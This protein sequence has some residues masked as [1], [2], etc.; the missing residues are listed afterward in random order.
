MSII[1]HGEH[2]P[3]ESWD[4]IGVMDSQDAAD[5]GVESSTVAE[6]DGDAGGLSPDERRALVVLLKNPF[7]TSESNPREWKTTLASRAAIGQRLNDLYLELAVDLDREVAYKRPVTSG[8]GARAFPTLLY[9]AAWK[10]EETALLVF[11]R[12]RERSER[13]R[14]EVQVRVSRGEMLDYLREN[15]P[16]SATNK[17]SDDRRGDRAID[18]IKRAGLLVRTDEEGV[19]RISPAIEPMLPIATLNRLLTWLHERLGEDPAT[20]EDV[21]EEMGS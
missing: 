15:R 2:D 13:A 5:E 3:E 10:R 4:S 14:G 17:V 1:E 11:L 12:V 7:I 18:A 20:R 9:D 21:T 19:Y 16:D 8:T 6:F